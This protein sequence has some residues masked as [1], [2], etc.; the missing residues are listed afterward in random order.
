MNLP[1]RET[2]LY[3]KFDLE[4]DIFYFR[5]GSFGLVSF[6]G[7]NYNLK[8]RLTP[9]Q[10]K[11]LTKEKSFCPIGSNCYVNIGKINSFTGGIVY[12]GPAYRETKHLPVPWWKQAQLQQLLDKRNEARQ[13]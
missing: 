12:F 5:V 13:A 7:K 4:R 10:L 2:D 6:H 8:K 11:K 3:E 9:D 1:L